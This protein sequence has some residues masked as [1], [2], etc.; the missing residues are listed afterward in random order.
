MGK[1]AARMTDTVMT[2]NDPTDMPVG[3]VIVAGAPTV[4][5]NKLPAA[6]QGDK[7]IAVDT[8]IIM[9]PSP[10]GPVPTPLPHPFNGMI[11]LNCSTSVFIQGMPAATQDS[12]ATNMPPHIPQGGPFQKP[13]MN[14]GKIIMG[15]PNVMIGGGGGGGGGGS[16]SGGESGSGTS[17]EAEVEEGHQLNVQFTDRGGNPIVGPRYR[18]SSPDG[19]VT[20]GPLAGEVRR[21]GVSEGDHEI[22]LTA[23]TD[24][25]WSKKSAV[26]GDTVKL[27]IETAGIESGEA[28]TFRIM[29]KDAGFADRQLT[30]L[31]G[32]VS[33][34]KAEVEWEFDVGEGYT[35]T[36]RERMQRRYTSPSF[37]FV[38]E[39]SGLSQ[40]SGI[41]SYKDWIELR[42][43]DDEGNPLANKQYTLYLSNGEVR[44]G[45]LDSNGYAREENLPPGPVEVSIDPRVSQ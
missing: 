39:V 18:V 17:A 30:E 20:E 36:Q 38:A 8:H 14:K 26:V 24:A 5:I 34:D 25:Q 22:E 21:G 19:T 31:E 15:S 45:F 43:K 32:E 4:L 33:G 12:E 23:I 1:P 16:G 41:L 42:I 27:A 44:S 28:V 13:P 37:Y 11:N 10:G 2:C 7:V 9:I 29:M 35:R 3:K 40:R 6:K